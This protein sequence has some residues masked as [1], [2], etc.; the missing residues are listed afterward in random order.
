MGGALAARGYCLDSPTGAP[1]APQALQ[2][3][4]SCELDGLPG[5]RDL[6]ERG[7]HGCGQGGRGVD[8]ANVVVGPGPSWLPRPRGLLLKYYPGLQPDHRTA[9][10][11]LAA[12]HIPVGRRGYDGLPKA[13]SCRH[14]EPSTADGRFQQ[15]LPH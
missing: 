9:D 1:L 12:R 4:F 11:T 15:G 5:P 10:A 7:H 3:L 2:V 14:D 8:M 13:Q 6:N